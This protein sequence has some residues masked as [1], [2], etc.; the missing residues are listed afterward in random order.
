MC[1]DISPELYFKIERIKEDGT[2]EDV[3]DAVTTW[4]K[5]EEF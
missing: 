4:K 5:R 3:F 1:I 2:K